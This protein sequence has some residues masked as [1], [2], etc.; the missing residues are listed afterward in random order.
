MAKLLEILRLKR[1]RVRGSTQ[2]RQLSRGEAIRL[3]LP[4]SFS[5][6]HDAMTPEDLDWLFASLDPTHESAQEGVTPGSTLAV[7]GL[8][9]SDASHELPLPVEADEVVSTPSVDAWNPTFNFLVPETDIASVDEP[10][11]VLA[12]DVPDPG[13]AAEVEDDADLQPD[14]SERTRANQLAGMLLRELDESSPRNIEY[15]TNI[16]LSRRWSSAQR[17]VRELLAAHY[18][19]PAVHLI[20]EISEAWRQ[21]DWLDQQVGEFHR[22]HTTLTWREAASL[23]DFLG[24]YADLGEVMDFVEV[25]HHAW[26]ARPHL[27]RLHARFKDY[28]LLERIARESHNKAFGWFDCLDP[29]DGRS[30]D[31]WSN[32][33]FSADW[34]EDELPG[35]V[36]RSVASRIFAGDSLESMIQ[37]HDL[38][39]WMGA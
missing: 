21:C 20:F 34:W 23:V 24:E 6:R 12:F 1:P 2:P 38:I 9:S 7:A 10:P 16:I 30:F 27:R 18:S 28:L 29:H 4:S 35:P 5:N 19:V 36:V 37:S 33:E 3:P 15:I 32:V 31:G 22:H 8:A 14:I 26:R 13:A 25:E 11:E 17:K 39:D